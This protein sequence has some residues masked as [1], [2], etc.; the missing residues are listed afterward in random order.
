[1]AMSTDRCDV[2]V[3]GAG[4]AGLSAAFRL[5]RA[6]LTVTV[7][8]ARD[9]IG[10]RLHTLRDPRAPVPVELG[11]EF[12]HGEARRT[13]RL[14]RDAGVEPVP[15][16]GESWRARGGRVEPGEE[17]WRGIGRVFAGLDPRRKPDRSFAAF[18]RA[19]GGRLPAQDLEAALAFVE[20]FFAADPEVVGERGLAR[21]SSEGAADSSRVPGGYDLLARHLADGLA[22][23][24]ILLG[25][26]ARRVTWRPGHVE[27]DTVASTNGGA[28]TTLQAA[29]V[30]VTV[31]LP[32]LAR[33]DS[34]AGLAFDPPLP[35]LERALQ[36]LVMGSVVRVTLAFD[37]PLRGADPLLPAPRGRLGPPS[38]LHATGRSFSAFWTPEPPEAPALI[39]WSGGSRSTELP[40][41]TEA[42]AQRALVDLAAAT[43]TDLERL[44]TALTGAWHHDWRSDPW[45]LGAYAYVAVGGS[46]APAALARP[47]EST[48][49]LAGE[50]TSTEGIGTVEGA[51]E[52]GERAADSIL[53][54]S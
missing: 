36:G 21:E 34:D 52:S 35:G 38:F 5:T 37:R 50:A 30:V 45:A 28:P 44:R 17:V 8:E 16:T 42:V 22:P 48:V 12:V 11:A 20:G 6:G 32:I 26:T 43:G 46:G 54:G 31:P 29:A 13:H 39:A 15:L 49:Y 7:V 9:R 40:V 24:S 27:V 2:L 53:A 25:R 3:V 23:D 4:V 41:G 51:L 1:M 47:V 14:L 10:G 18:L 19:E 33:P